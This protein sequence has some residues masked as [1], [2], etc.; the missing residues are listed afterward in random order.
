[1][2][3]YIEESKLVVLK[4][5]KIIQELDIIRFWEKSGAR[6][7]PVGSLKMELL[8]KNLDID[9][10]IYTKELNIKSSFNI[11]SN[12]CSSPKIKKV[13]FVNSA[14]TPEKCFEWHL[15]Y[16]NTPQELWR[17]DLIQIQEGSF[18]DGYFEQVAD[19][20]LKLLTEEKKEIILK[21][22]FET[23]ENVKI[24]GIEYYKAVLQDHIKTWDEFEAW[25]S[26]HLFT[27]IIEW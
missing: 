23:P 7:N 6:I 10:H 9:F 16:E 24:P 26:K 3:K 21:L 22:K 11:I 8:A 4:A 14:E 19:N 18:Y 5:Q 25:R 12:I 27:G 15:F 1:M 13:E 17:I 20:I 2:K